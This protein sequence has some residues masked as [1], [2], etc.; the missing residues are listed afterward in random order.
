MTLLKGMFD[1]SSPYLKPDR[2]PDVLAAIQV[3]AVS[4]QYRGPL[5]QWTYFLSGVKPAKSQSQSEP[6]SDSD[7]DFESESASGPDAG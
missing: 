3:M 7:P 6:D 4:D 5:K 2:L 1:V